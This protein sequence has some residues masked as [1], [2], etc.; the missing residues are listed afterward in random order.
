VS[1]VLE[2]FRRNGN[3]HTLH[4]DEEDRHLVEAHRWYVAVQAHTC[5]A[6]YSQPGTGGRV[7]VRLHQLIVPGCPQV[8][9]VNG[10]GLDNRRANLRPATHQQ[11]MRN[12]RTQARSEAGYKGVFSDGNGR[13]RARI[14]CNGQR[15]NLGS[16][17]TPE[18]AALIYNAAA[19]KHFGE[20][21][22]LNV[23]PA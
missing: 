2:I 15:F 8:D 22:Y 3:R 18:E 10:N 19:E 4:Y 12:K 6:V 5:Y 21:A 23:V 1:E 16:Y 9:H 13:W 11:N 20:F 7:K 14:F 17:D